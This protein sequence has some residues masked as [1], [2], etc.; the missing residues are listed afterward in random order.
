MAISPLV[1]KTTPGGRPTLAGTVSRDRDRLLKYLVGALQKGEK[2]K[3]Q[4]TARER[5]RRPALFLLKRLGRNRL[6]RKRGEAEL[7]QALR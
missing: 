5:R 6:D 4:Q 1:L 7:A 2:R 3:L